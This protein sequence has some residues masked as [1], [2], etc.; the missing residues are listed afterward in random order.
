[1]PSSKE[2]C[3]WILGSKCSIS[4]WWKNDI[5]VSNSFLWVS[6]PNENKTTERKTEQPPAAWARGRQQSRG[7]RASLSMETPVPED[8][9]HIHWLFSCEWHR[10]GTSPKGEMWDLE[11]CSSSTRICSL[12]HP[13]APVTAGADGTS[14]W[15]LGMAGWDWGGQ[16]PAWAFGVAREQ[17]GTLCSAQGR[18]ALP[19]SP[20]HSTHSCPRLFLPR[21]SHG[22]HRPQN[23]CLLLKD[24]SVREI[25]RQNAI[26]APQ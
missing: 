9:W 22:T 4:G 14:R 2:M 19:P 16:E 13:S 11:N 7:I 15:Q 12:N 21:K 25:C 23:V 26:Q 3:C 24:T 10:N 17:P 20:R 1:M 5:K 6:W 18:L 8:S